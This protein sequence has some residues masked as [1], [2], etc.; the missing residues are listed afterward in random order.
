MSRVLVVSSD[1]VGSQMAGPA[2]RAIELGRVLSTKHE[3]TLAVP[4]VFDGD[5]GLPTVRYTHDS[6]ARQAEGYDAIVVGGLTLAF[7][8]GL[9]ALP[10][11]IIVDVLPFTLENLELYA[12]QPLPDRLRDS[13]G[14]LGALLALLRRGDFFLCLSAKQRDFWLGIL[15]AVGRINPYTYEADPTLE[16]L[17]AVVP[18]GLPAEPPRRLEPALKGRWPGIGADDFVVYWGGGLY[19]WLDPLTAV[20]AVAAASREDARIKLFFPG[21]RHPN[22]SV[23]R[24]AMVDQTMRLSDSLG[25]TGNAVFF[26]DWVPYERRADYLL[27]ADLGISLHFNHLE[28]AFSFRTRMLDYFWSGLPIVAT[29]GDTLAEIVRQRDLGVVVPPCDAEAVA[30]AILG[31]ARV[32]DLRTRY[33]GRFAAVAQEM[34][35]QRCAA[36]LLAFCDSPRPAPD[37]AA[38]YRFPLA[39]EQPRSLGGSLVGK[40]MTSLRRGGLGGLLADARG[41]IRWRFGR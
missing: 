28:T 25:L 27:D 19:D 9:A 15:H 12:R 40:S 31:L 4:N 36:P 20:R 18:F 6:L 22:P 38:G 14:L 16:Q 7:A 26:N 35:W 32:P 10:L 41:Y 23:H 5:L 39:G 13:E 24:M 33:A 11:P 3:V 34:T 1:V 17:A 21:T 2:I 30:A 29:S 8:G 37:R